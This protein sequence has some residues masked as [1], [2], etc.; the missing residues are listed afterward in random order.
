MIKQV[1]L[2]VNEIFDKDYLECLARKTGLIKRKRKLDPKMFLENLIL[3]RLENANGSLED[4][5]YEFC[6]S[7]VDITKQALHKKLNQTS[8]NFVEKIVEK[9]LEDMNHHQQ[10][11]L[12]GLPFVKNI[13]VIDSSEIRL[14][15]VLKEIFP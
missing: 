6:K 7:D 2:K 8:F 10:I 11:Q 14:N 13:R 1:M 15:G 4:L 5:A 3:L 12:Q 9:L